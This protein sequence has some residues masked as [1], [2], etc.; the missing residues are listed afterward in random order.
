LRLHREGLKKVTRR[1]MHDR[2]DTGFV[3]PDGSNLEECLEDA[4]QAIRR[5][6]LPWFATIRT[7]RRAPSAR[8]D[9]R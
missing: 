5:E 3:R 9:G 4:L 7:E 1:D 2:A 6:G 8:G